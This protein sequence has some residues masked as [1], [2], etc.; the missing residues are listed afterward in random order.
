[1][2]K[3]C[4]RVWIATF[5]FTASTC[6]SAQTL[7]VKR[8]DAA[9]VP[10][11]KLD[12]TKILAPNRFSQTAARQYVVVEGYIDYVAKAWPEADGDYHFEMQK[13]GA[14]RGTGVSPDGLVCEID[15]ALQLSNSA[16]LRQI[17]DDKS[18]YRKARV[19]GYLRFGTEKT[20]HSGIKVY[21]IGNGAT[22]EGHWEI[23]PV[24]KII[25]IDN[26]PPFQIGP[27]A[28]YVSTMRSKRYKL[29]DTNFKSQTASNYGALRGNV[30]SI[31][32]S[33]N[34]SG[35]LDVA[36]EVNSTIY[37]ATIPQYYV[38]SF[39]PGTKTVRFVHLPNFASIHYSLKPSDTR[40]RTLYGLRNWTFKPGKATPALQPVEMIR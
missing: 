7:N 20:G 23:H 10:S 30:K 4:P 9:Y 15:P 26:K 17:K 24:E 22:I 39:N 28:Q 35:D 3:T 16:V 32:A 21:D 11:Q 1:M 6:V 25:S 29:N 37:T 34:Q 36:L 18:T 14:Q 27:S 12:P 8:F 31:K 40:V 38:A 19:Y 5:L 13:T 33:S 2:T